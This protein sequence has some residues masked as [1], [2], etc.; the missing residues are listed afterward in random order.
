MPFT[1]EV[2]TPKPQDDP[3]SLGHLACAFRG[4]HQRDIDAALDHQAKGGGRLGE[5]L[6]QEAKLGSGELTWLLRKQHDMRN[7]AASTQDTCRL[8]D[9]VADVTAS[10]LR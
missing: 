4:L 2:E 9:Y 8:L 1:K 6:V 7:G 5:C 10:L 3:T